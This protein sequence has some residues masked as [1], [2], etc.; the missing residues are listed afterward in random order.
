MEAKKTQLFEVLS[1]HLQT[2]LRE[3]RACIAFVENDTEELGELGDWTL[4]PGYKS[5]KLYIK[6]CY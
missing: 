1:T 4:L 6:C 2:K 5:E 3:D